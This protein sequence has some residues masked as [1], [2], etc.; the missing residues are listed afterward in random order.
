VVA[1][2][3]ALGDLI[4]L[5]ERDRMT[6]TFESEQRSTG[7][8]ALSF[9]ALTLGAVLVLVGL[10]CG[11]RSAMEPSVE[12]DGVVTN[13]NMASPP[14]SSAPNRGQSPIS[15][16]TMMPSEP[17]RENLNP[18]PLQD[19][20]FTV[21]VQ[22]PVPVDPVSE[23]PVLRECDDGTSVLANN[24]SIVDSL[25]GCTSLYGLHVSGLLD[26][27]PLGS[28]RRVGAGGLRLE[29]GVVSFAG[30]EAL[31]SAVSLVV[32]N[33]GAAD[34]R[35]FSSLRH[36]EALEI[37]SDNFVDLQGL[38][39]A[40]GIRSI[41][42][43]QLSRLE[44]LRGLAI[45]TELAELHLEGVQSLSSISELRG[46]TRI[47]ERLVLSGVGLEA[48]PFE[49]LDGAIEEVIINY[50]NRLT[51][52]SA[53]HGLTSIG[54]LEIESNS[55]LES[56]VTFERLTELDFLDLVQNT[57][58]VTGPSFPLLTSLGALYVAE[59]NLLSTLT[60][61]AALESASYIDIFANPSL[62]SIDLRNL[63]DILSLYV[64][65]NPALDGQGLA[66]E[67][68]DV[69]SPL[70][71]VAP[72][73]TSLPIE[74]CPWVDDDICDSG[75]PTLCSWGSDPACLFP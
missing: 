22:E 9:P 8:C 53:L 75:I 54:L 27:R 67:L 64:Y 61:F 13:T 36:L 38:E 72:D 48:L 32:R 51:D 14:S 5:R 63:R 33:N 44:S 26:S 41:R 4:P 43:L 71:R 74:P 60:G 17:P 68:A 18:V 1:G 42:L 19:P 50:N 62:A 45:G 3:L 73:Q 47:S 49:A 59:N 30:L 65:Q 34:L 11:G 35:A 46:V 69:T 23:P 21:P 57:R 25:A 55:A 31:E 24:Q 39:N 56:E 66:A 52:I 28:L 37:E 7:V 15:T 29:H 16:P 2:W 40:V 6:L 58:L 20:P 12:G 10:G 70:S